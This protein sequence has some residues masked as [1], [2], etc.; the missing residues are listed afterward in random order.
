[1][2]YRYFYDPN[3]FAYKTDQAEPCSVCR[4]VGTY[5]IENDKKRIL[6]DTA[7]SNAYKDLIT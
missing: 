1:M 3:N 4:K 6:T 5:E 2:K 7:I